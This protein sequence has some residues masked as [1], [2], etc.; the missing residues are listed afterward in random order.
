MRPR[1]VNA[2]GEAGYFC[3]PQEMVIR[4]SETGGPPVKLPGHQGFGMRFVGLVVQIELEVASG[5]PRAKERPDGARGQMALLRARKR[6]SCRFVSNVPKPLKQKQVN[7]GD[8]KSC[9]SMQKELSRFAVQLPHRLREEWVLIAALL[10]PLKQF[11]SFSWARIRDV[12]CSPPAF[13]QD[14]DHHRMSSARHELL[15]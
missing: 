5:I 11:A 3:A 6:V 14:E 2:K 12:I 1:P 7:E 13:G 15:S 8:K 4:W 10:F 9:T